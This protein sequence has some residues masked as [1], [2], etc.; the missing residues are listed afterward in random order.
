LSQELIGIDQRL[1]TIE[2]HEKEL[3]W[4]WT[5]QLNYVMIEL[6]YPQTYTTIELHNVRS[7]CL[8]VSAS[9]KVSLLP[10]C[11]AVDL[12]DWVHD[13][14]FDHHNM[15]A[16]H[17]T[18]VSS[19]AW[20]H[21]GD[22]GWIHPQTK[23]LTKDN[24]KKQPK[25]RTRSSS[26]IHTKDWRVYPLMESST[27]LSS[28]SIAHICLQQLVWDLRCIKFGAVP[29]MNEWVEMDELMWT[30]FDVAFDAKV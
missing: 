13:V 26:I 30:M 22:P 21:D 11:A 7:T 3:I 27:Q 2:L 24:A 18:K 1:P 25:E 14:Q 8:G 16:C 28:Q 5:W 23:L 6:D 12:I 19:L 4:G 9:S 10:F 15:K 29:Q 17:Q 20:S